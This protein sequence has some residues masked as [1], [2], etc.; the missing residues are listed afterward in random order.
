[1][2]T[3]RVIV[4]V[5]PPMAQD[6]LHLIVVGVRRKKQGTRRP[7]TR[8]QEQDHLPQV[9]HLVRPVK[10]RRRT[11]IEEEAQVPEALHALPD[12]TPNIST[13]NNETDKI[14]GGD[15]DQDQGHRRV[16]GNGAQDHRLILHGS[17][18]EGDTDLLNIN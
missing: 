9:N 7:K 17:A 2:V 8:S 15:L 18:T 12:H 3:H 13:G 11:V 6:R 1:M 16:I 14:T 10:K 5:H 4:Q